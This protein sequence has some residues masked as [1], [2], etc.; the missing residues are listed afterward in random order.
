MTW[1]RWCYAKGWVGDLGGGGGGG[2]LG[3][4]GT[5]GGGGGGGTV[6]ACKF[7]YVIEYDEKGPNN[8]NSIF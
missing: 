3:G 6:K 2:G 4:G 8:T 7:Q 5:W 1:E